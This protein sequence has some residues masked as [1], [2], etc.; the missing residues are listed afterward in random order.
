MISTIV[1]ISFLDFIILGKLFMSDIQKDIMTGTIFL[2]G[3]FGF[4]SG[5]F[6]ISSALFAT[7]TVATHV[8]FNSKASKNDQ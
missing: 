3:V 5:E 8:N 1:E 2:S 4:V 6:V 7:A